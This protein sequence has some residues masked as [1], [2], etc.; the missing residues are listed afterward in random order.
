[1]MFVDTR[2]SRVVANDRQQRSTVAKQAKDAA[3]APKK[4]KRRKPRWP[5]RRPAFA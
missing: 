3:K 5:R 4:S 2:M 1:M